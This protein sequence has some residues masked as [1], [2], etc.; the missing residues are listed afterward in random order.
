MHPGAQAGGLP[1]V[2]HAGSGHAQ[3]A[4]RG[5]GRGGRGPARQP[6]PGHARRR[7]RG[8]GRRPARPRIG[9]AVH[10]PDLQPATQAAGGTARPGRHQRRPGAAAHAHRQDTLPQH[11][12][13]L[14]RGMH[15]RLDT[16]NLRGGHRPRLGATARPGTPQRRGGNRQ[17]LGR[18]F[19]RLAPEAVTFARAVTFR[20]TCDLWGMSWG[21]RARTL[22]HVRPLRCRGRLSPSSTTQGDSMNSK[23]IR[24]TVGVMLLCGASALMAVP[25]AAQSSS[26]ASNAGSS[27]TA[28]A[29]ELV[30][31][32]LKPLSATTRGTVS[33]EGKSV[34]YAA[35]AGT[36]VV[37]GT[38][39]DE[40]TPQVAMGYFAYFKEGADRAKRPITFIYSG[41]P[42]S[43]TVWLHMGAWGPKRV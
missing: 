33:V 20:A 1:G 6:L 29:N 30:Q 28:N 9:C 39:N 23:R 16:G 15:G 10:H 21:C 22:G 38:G 5:V 18:Q 31:Q 2:L 26:Q 35:V 37:N 27:S 40:A 24:V 17:L 25:A 3:G 12:G 13:G 4:A 8:T 36:L 14:R 43:S 41:G 11:A 32:L 42:G 34:S 19:A 7:R